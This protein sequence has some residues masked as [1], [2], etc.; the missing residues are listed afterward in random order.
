[1]SAPVATHDVPELNHSS[2]AYSLTSAMAYYLDAMTEIGSKRKERIRMA[3]AFARDAV[4]FASGFEEITMALAI[5]DKLDDLQARRL[6][7]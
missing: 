5:A 1:M 7:V 4:K 3:K 2:F 6:D